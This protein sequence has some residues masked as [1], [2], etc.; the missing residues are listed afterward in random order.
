[1]SKCVLAYS[2]W[3]GWV[4]PILT[5]IACMCRLNILIQTSHA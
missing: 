4:I 5:C 3:S 1:M 2:E